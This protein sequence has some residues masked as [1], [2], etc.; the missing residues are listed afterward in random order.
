MGENDKY[1]SRSDEL[2]NINI[3]A[4]VLAVLAGAAAL[5]TEGVGAMAASLG[6]DVAELVGR[7]VVT[8]GVRI[9]IAE[10]KVAI[11]LSILVKYGYVVPDVARE[12]QEAVKVA[13][14]NTSGLNVVCVN[15]T[16]AGVTFGK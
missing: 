5:E 1:I 2:G 4:E 10:E 7:K 6:S 9:V 11:D 15:V 16:V 12:V 8:K 14:E 3:S 13:L